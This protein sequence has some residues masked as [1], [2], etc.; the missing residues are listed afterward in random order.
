MPARAGAVTRLGYVPVVVAVEGVAVLAES[1][2]V[3]EPGGV[4]PGGT[5]IT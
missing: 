4:D 1:R 5:G 2:V 3:V